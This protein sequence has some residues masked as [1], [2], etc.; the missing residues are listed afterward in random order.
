MKVTIPEWKSLPDHYELRNRGKYG[1]MRGTSMKIHDLFPFRYT[2][3]VSSQAWFIQHRHRGSKHQR[4]GI[5]LALAISWL[6]RRWLTIQYKRLR[7]T[8]QHRL[9]LVGEIKI[10]PGGIWTPDLRIRSPKKA[11]KTRVS[12]LPSRLALRW[13]TTD[14]P[15]SLS[16]ILFGYVWSFPVLMVTKRLQL[17]AI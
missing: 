5:R 12:K 11:K 3:Q 2:V 7:R 8:W 16:F 4:L 1:Q 14:W 10:T 13:D 15:I 9:N 17:C 6:V